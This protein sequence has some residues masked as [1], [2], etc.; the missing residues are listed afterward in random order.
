[1][2]RSKIL[3]WQ[4]AKTMMDKVLSM[5]FQKR[6]RKWTAASTALANGS[7]LERITQR[8]QKMKRS[9]ERDLQKCLLEL[10]FQYRQIPEINDAVPERGDGSGKDDGLL[11][12]LTVILLVG[13][14]AIIE[15]VL[16]E[17]TEWVID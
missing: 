10:E 17:T 9:I 14:Y 16:P 6:Y 8:S 11:S 15:S 4:T 2:D 3:C 5:G 7:L 13:Q 1:M 12:R